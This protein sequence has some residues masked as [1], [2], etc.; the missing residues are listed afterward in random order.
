VD[1]FRSTGQLEAKE[2]GL[3]LLAIGLRDS[4]AFQHSAA[5]QSKGHIADPLKGCYNSLVHAMDNLG[6]KEILTI[7]IGMLAAG[8]LTA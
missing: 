3:A 4:A 7:V 5:C 1:G 8:A 2:P 6:K